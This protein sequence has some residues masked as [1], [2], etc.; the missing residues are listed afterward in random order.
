MAKIPLA[1]DKNYCS[2]WKVFE[3]VRELLQ[4]TKDADEDGYPMSINHY[5]RTSRLEIVNKGIYVD[6]SKLLILGKSDKAPG[7][8][9]GQFGEGFVLGVLALMRQGFDVRFQNGDMSWSVSFEHPDAGHPFEGNELLTFKSRKV[10]PTPD[11]T[12]EIDGVTTE[13]WDALKKLFLFLEPPKK[14]DILEMTAGTLLMASEYKGKVFSRGIFVHTF[15]DLACGY[16]MNNLQLD[17]D[18]RMVDSWDL[19]YKLGALWQ[20]ACKDKPELAAPRV[21]D[22]AKA[23]AAE[24]RQ[25]HYHADAKLLKSV[26][27]RFDEEHGADAAPVSTMAAARAVEGVGAKPVVVSNT[28]KELLQKGGLTAES[29]T[30]RLEGTIEARF[31]PSDLSGDEIAALA[32]LEGLLPEAV[33]VSFR[34]DKLACR[35]IDNDTIV[36]VERRLLAGK[37]KALLTS[38]VNA[39]AK[40]RNIPALDMLLEYMAREAEPVFTATA[41]AVAGVDFEVC[42]ECGKAIPG[43]TPTIMDAHHHHSCI[44]HAPTETAKS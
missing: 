33:V 15:E 42:D 17:R 14:K 19:H 38:A 36:G 39:E 10:T 24:V 12:V 37:F 27:D 31:S 1:I 11:F 20:E 40:R 23:D 32:R 21:Y 16:D 6:P 44:L 26:R 13:I 18:R 4:N 5:P 30:A 34:G 41:S 8:K 35:L 25:V 3:G 22:M 7:Q 9:R 28:L 43:A 29:V 2:S